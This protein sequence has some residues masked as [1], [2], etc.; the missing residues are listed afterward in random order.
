MVTGY[1]SQCQLE[2]VCSLSREAE[3]NLAEGQ[4]LK[5]KKNFAAVI[6][7]LIVTLSLFE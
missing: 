7:A 1:S 5:N 6:L 2:Q 4:V 3:L